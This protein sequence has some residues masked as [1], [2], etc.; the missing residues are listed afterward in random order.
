[1]AIDFFSDRE[2]GKA[3]L[4]SEEITET[5]FNGIIAIYEKYQLN[6]SK[7]FPDF[8]PDNAGIIC[9]FSAT[10]FEDSIKAFIP[11][12]IARRYN[13]SYSDSLPDKYATLDFIEYIYENMW[14]YTEGTYHSFFNH[15]HL[16][17]PETR[18]CRTNFISNINK[19]FERNGIVFYL[20]T[21]GKIK[22]QLPLEM[23]VLISQMKISTSDD[24][25]NELINQA[26]IDIRKP[27]IKDRAYSLEKMWDAFERMKTVYSTNKKASAE[28]LY[29]SVGNS[30]DEFY[31]LLSEESKTLTGIGNKYQIRHFETDKIEIKYT[32]H[33]DYLF[34]RMI[35]LINLC[36]EFI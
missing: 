27:E 2:L 15:S 22:R 16:S 35:S 5:V 13:G 12:M 6:L 9:G 10:S 29:Q 19:L 11:G 8:C 33:I 26:V 14:D 17:F 4:N 28:Q 31:L 20:D 30:T 34:Y 18:L 1:M 32:K 21:D 24:R 3:Q 25:L 23:D 7:G 36:I